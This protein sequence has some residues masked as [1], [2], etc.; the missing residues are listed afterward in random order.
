MKTILILGAGLVAKPIV[1]YLLSKNYHLTV[2]SNTPDR[3]D[4]MIDNHPNGT[5]VFWDAGD[6]QALDA[7]VAASDITVSLLPYTF[8]VMV[9]RHCIAHRKNM[10]T[11]SYVKPEMRELDRQ[12]REA[13]VII[14]NEIGLDPGI[15][16]MSAMR[17]IDKIHER[18]GAVIEFY[19]I[20]GALPAPEAA[21]N[22]F[23]YKFSWSPK[24]VV[25][26]GNNDAVYLRHGKITEVPTRD[27]FKNPFRVDYPGLGQLEVYPN[28]D[29]LAYQEI[30]GIPEARTIFRGTFR[31]PGWCET[32]DEMKRLNLISAD[33]FDMTGM[34]YADMVIHQ[35]QSLQ[36]NGPIKPDTAAGAGAV[37]AAFLGIPPESHA[38]QAM[39]WLGLFDET[40]MNRGT[41]STF[42]VTSDLMIAKMSLGLTER[43]MVVMQHTFLA[44]YSD[45]RKEVIRSRMLD[46]GTL[47]TDTSIARTVALPAAIGVEMILRGEI[48]VTGVHVPVIPEIYNPVLDQ[49]EALNIRMVEEFGLPLSENLQ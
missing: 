33:P 32:L 24:G 2:A 8:H 21:T 17:I 25:M 47:E 4:A 40:P 22:P 27:L 46:F 15:D 18:E 37:T 35:I 28:R 43:D 3:S 49:L 6:E 42:E 48:K 44:G 31:Y 13:G 9:A 39:E 12:A 10:V 19:S 14:L 5:S 7:L 30:Y 45:G 26:A 38:L 41:D 11:T 23:R 16:H 20:C 1:R 36:G 29:S 34:S